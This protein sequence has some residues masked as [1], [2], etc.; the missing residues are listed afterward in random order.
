MRNI[1]YFY[2]NFNSYLQ[3]ASIFAAISI[4]NNNSFVIIDNNSN[5]SCFKIKFGGLFSTDVLNKYITF[6]NMEDIFGYSPDNASNSI[7]LDLRRHM[8]HKESVV[9]WC[10][11]RKDYPNERL[12]KLLR[13]IDLKNINREI[14]TIRAYDVSIVSAH[15]FIELMRS[16]EYLMTD[17]EFVKSSFYGME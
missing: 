8:E 12:I 14:K 3:F 2:N 13:H 1:L 6:I 5:F 15:I 4:L 16:H 10:H 11:A 9:L 7:A 17:K